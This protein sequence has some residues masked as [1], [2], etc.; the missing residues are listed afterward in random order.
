[1]PLPRL[2]GL[3]L[4]TDI[5]TP[6]QAHRFVMRLAALA[7]VLAVGFD[8]IQQLVFFLDWPTALRS[9]ALSAA[10]A[11][12]ISVPIG[13]AIANA[14]LGLYRAK[15]EVVEL[16]RRDPLTGLLN[17]RAL[18]DD[19]N[20][21]ARLMAL[22]IVDIDRFKR[23]NDTHGH[24]A[25]DEVIRFIAQM[26]VAELSS[27][28]RVGRLGGEEFALLSSEKDFERLMTSL[29]DFR[30]RVAATPVV[31]GNVAAE[32]TI[33]A[34]VARREADQ[35]FDDLYR[36]ADRALYLAKAAG[37][38]Q[39]VVDSASAS[40]APLSSQPLAEGLHASD[41]RTYRRSAE[42]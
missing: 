42:A 7:V 40:A 39:I 8:V 36:A 21:Q 16:S 19:A 33:S 38:N 18:F 3:M 14:Y 5:R 31:V 37:R 15:E 2:V 17:R 9:W 4:A 12:V 1:M 41:R 27:F 6:A 11:I 23:I 20:E 35:S 34:G 13:V 26:M 24:M 30:D 29:W 25:G 28:G 32:V 10:V 22:V